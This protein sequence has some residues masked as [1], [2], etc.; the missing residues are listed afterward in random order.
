MSPSV[1]SMRAMLRASQ[2][3]GTRPP[4]CRKPKMPRQ[5]PRMFGRRDAAEIG[6]AAD[7][8]QKPHVA[9]VA[10]RARV[11]SGIGASA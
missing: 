2:S 3:S 11:T 6:D 7:V 9:R 10:Q 4:S 8:P 5:Q 1:R